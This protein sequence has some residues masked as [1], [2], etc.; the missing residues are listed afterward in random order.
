LPCTAGVSQNNSLY[1]NPPTNFLSGV[2][3]CSLQFTHANLLQFQKKS[4][5]R[6][7][8]F[9][10]AP[11]RFSSKYLAAAATTWIIRVCNGRQLLD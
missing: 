11:G 6:S 3:N 9:I 2:Y 1:I 7:V 8:T 10:S 4:W 5:A